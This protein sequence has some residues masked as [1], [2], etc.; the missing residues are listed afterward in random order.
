MMGDRKKRYCYMKYC[1]KII[2]KILTFVIIGIFIFAI[3]QK[4]F[5]PKRF[6]YD[7]SNDTGKL[8]YFIGE[9]ENSVDLLVL[10]TSH[11]SRGILPM[12]MYEL[13]GIKSY[14]LSTS[15]Q[16]IEVTYYILQ[17]AIKTQNPNVVIWDVSSLYINYADTPHWKMAMDEMKIGK[18]KERFIEEYLKSF[19]DTGET[20]ADLLFPL[21]GYHT[22]WKEL[23]EQDFKL[24]KNK[25]CA[26]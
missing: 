2:F 24:I 18:N 10:G 4:I 22:R 23:V 16:P 8:R 25:R 21:L 17:E 3:L 14:N 9:E 6:P 19:Y 26:D 12:E 13:Y 11:S 1:S 15:V 20:M 5:I 7:K